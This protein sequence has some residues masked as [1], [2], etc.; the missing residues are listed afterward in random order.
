VIFFA[1][2]CRNSDDDKEANEHL[3]DNQFNFDNNPEDCLFIYRSPIRAKRLNEAE[4]AC[5]RY[6]RLKQIH[7]WSIIR[8]SLIYLGFFSFI[9]ILNYSNQ[10]SNSYLQVNHLRK[11]LF[12]SRQIDLDYT[13]VILEKSFIN[14]NEYI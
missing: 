9:C 6:Q 7:M 12:N 10:H 1:C 3:D 2:F 5:A 14:R 8:E 4:V 13:K 11:Y